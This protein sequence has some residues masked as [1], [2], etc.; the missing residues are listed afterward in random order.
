MKLSLS[1]IFDHITDISLKDLVVQDLVDRFNSTTAEIESFTKVDLDLTLFTIVRLIEKNEFYCTVSSEEYEFQLDLPLRDGA[2]NGQA[3]LVK[4]NDSAWQWATLID[5]GG[6]KDDLIPALSVPVDMVAGRWKKSFPAQDYILDLSN[7]S[8]THRSDLWSHRGIAREFAA[9]LNVSLVPENEFLTDIKIKHQGNFASPTEKNPFTISIEDVQGCKQFA[10][11][12]VPFI[13]HTDS[14]LMMAFRLTLVG[15]KPIDA[16]VDATNYVMLDFGQ[17]MHAFDADKIG[18]LQLKPRMAKEGEVITLLDDETIGLSELD[19]VITNGSVPIALA[20]V[21]GGFSTK[22]TPST[23]RVLVEAGC[24]DGAIIRGAALRHKK[25]TES[26]IRFEKSVDP[27]LAMKALQRFIYLLQDQ[28]I[29]FQISDEIVVLGFYNKEHSI[30]ISNVMI[31][32]VLGVS[33]Q[34]EFIIKTLTLLGMNVSVKNDIVEDV[35][36]TVVIPSYRS[37]DIQLA[38]DIIEELGRFYGYT[39]IPQVLPKIE[40]K[41][42][43]TRMSEQVKD[44]KRIVA[45]GIKMH[46]V[47][48]YPLYDEEFLRELGYESQ[49]SVSL[50]NPVSDTNRRLVTSLIPHLLKNTKVNRAYLQDLRFFELARVWKKN[51]DDIQEKKVFA[52]L[53]AEPKHV[54]DFYQMKYEFS[55]IFELLSADVTWKKIDVP[56]IWF[57]PYKCAQLEYEGVII[58]Y[59][60][61]LH[62]DFCKAVDIKDAFIFELYIDIFLKLHNE[63]SDSVFVPLPKYQDSWFDV[64]MLISK[65]ITVAT[66]Q[67]TISSEDQRIFKIELVDFFYKEEW[68]DQHSITLRIFVRDDAKTLT[69]QEITLLYD[70]VV[71]A[72]KKYGA[73]IR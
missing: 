6:S 32:S 67:R 65:I 14:S 58:G 60:G 49:N 19:L 70:R 64:S 16:I 54:L 33:L 43:D 27:L 42:F 62:P 57:N 53:I 30:Q 56:S 21:M 41:A 22:V 8:I 39:R 52:A 7:T 5:W 26:S 61:V 63:K 4:K 25:R 12:N 38:E 2:L 59:A 34:Q 1:W 46:E 40:A 69:K 3:F 20:G 9:I 50:K 68:L 28:H 18:S 23:K 11:L 51:G 71:F 73:E 35:V 47:I 72:V 36:Y 48:N 15:I 55:R 31:S 24:F 29:K 10:V 66:L 45:F 37:R 44:I 13:K 17:P